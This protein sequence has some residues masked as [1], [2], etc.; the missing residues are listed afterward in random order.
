MLNP[1]NGKGNSERNS[2]PMPVHTEY[3]QLL[4]AVSDYA[5]AISEMVEPY[6]TEQNLA[7]TELDEIILLKRRLDDVSDVIKIL[8]DTV[9]VEAESRV[10]GLANQC[11]E[12]PS[13]TPGKVWRAKMKTRKGNVTLDIQGT[14]SSLVEQG[15]PIN[16]INTTFDANTKKGK[17]SHYLEIREVK[18]GQLDSE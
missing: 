9:K 8:S 15:I 10:K 1:R 3:N 5:L 6:I 13:Y 12:V 4:T 14:K 7:S 18:A 11:Y 16:I 2:K 17:D